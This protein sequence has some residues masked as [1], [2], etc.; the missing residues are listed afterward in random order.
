MIALAVAIGLQEGMGG[1]SL[2]LQW[3]ILNWLEFSFFILFFKYY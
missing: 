3:F 2:L 1:L